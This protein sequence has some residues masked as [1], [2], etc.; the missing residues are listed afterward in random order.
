[1][2]PGSRAD[3]DIL[4]SRYRLGAW[5]AAAQTG[6]RAPIG[7]RNGAGERLPCSVH[8]VLK[9]VR[10]GRVELTGE[11]P[12]C[13]FFVG[14]D[15]RSGERWYLEPPQVRALRKGQPVALGEKQGVFYWALGTTLYATSD[16]KLTPEDVVA[17]VNEADN[18][19]R[20]RLAKAHALQAMADQIDTKPKRQAIPSDVKVQV[21]QRDGGKCVECGSNRNI[22]FDHIIPLSLGGANSFRN[23]QLLCEDCNRRKGASLG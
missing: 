14:R 17:L 8:L 11:Y 18:K 9:V 12:K 15:Q 4:T 2:T 10:N 1:M 22:E 13:S 19:R 20:V 7:G 6:E 5:R 23:L 16:R 3:R 21:W